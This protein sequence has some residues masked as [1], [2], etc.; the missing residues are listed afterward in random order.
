[1]NTLQDSDFEEVDLPAER[2]AWHRWANALVGLAI[3]IVCFLAGFMLNQRTSQPT[4]SPVTPTVQV[5]PTAQVV[6]P[7]TMPAATPKP[8]QAAQQPVSNLPMQAEFVGFMVNDQ[9]MTCDQLRSN[10]EA[11]QT[12]SDDNRAMCGEQ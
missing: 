7:A 3:V 1:M 8:Y 9:V 5:W 12:L 6:T 2:F 4:A 11:W 10:A